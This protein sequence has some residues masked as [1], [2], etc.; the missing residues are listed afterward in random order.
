MSIS[1]NNTAFW[2]SRFWVSSSRKSILSWI[3]LSTFCCILYGSLFFHPKEGSSPL[4]S[5][6]I[7]TICNT[8]AAVFWPCR[9]SPSRTQRPDRFI[10]LASAS[11]APWLQ[12]KNS[13]LLFF[14][15]PECLKESMWG[16]KIDGTCSM[17]LSGRSTVTICLYFCHCICLWSWG[18][19]DPCLISSKC[20]K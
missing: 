16:T 17:M 3:I 20:R 10:L 7:C 1:S 19:I 9:Y 11:V 12:F 5:A 13:L 4:L 6:A 18:G 8:S 2:L 15:C 14:I